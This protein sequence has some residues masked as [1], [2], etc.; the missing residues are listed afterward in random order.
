MGE[1]G[2]AKSRSQGQGKSDL[3]SQ[4]PRSVG[5]GDQTGGHLTGSCRIEFGS[6]GNLGEE[7]IS[8]STHVTGSTPGASPKTQ[9]ITAVKKHERY[10]KNPSVSLSL[11]LFVT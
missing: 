9:G 8:A 6:V 3:C 1:F 10:E 4:S 7:V 2:T 5:D 11:S